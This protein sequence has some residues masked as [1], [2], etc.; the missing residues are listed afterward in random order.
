MQYLYVVLNCRCPDFT[1]RNVVLNHLLKQYLPRFNHVVILLP[2]SICLPE[3]TTLE[4]RIC[5]TLFH[6]H[7]FSFQVARL[8]LLTI[9][10]SLALVRLD[11]SCSI[12]SKRDIFDFL[13]ASKV[14][15]RLSSFVCHSP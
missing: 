15:L 11:L 10:L 6:Q 5:Q 12:C 7:S 13:V 3:L 1:L 9:I 4:S 14:L 2:L 8:V